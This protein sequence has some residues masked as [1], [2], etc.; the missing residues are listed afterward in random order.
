MSALEEALNA[1]ERVTGYRPVKSG[2]GYKARCPCHEDHNPSLSVKMNGR[3]L[4]HCFAGCSYDRIVAAL[5][6]APEP[7]SDAS[8]SPR[9]I[10]V[11]YRYRDESGAEVRQKVRYA[12]KDF[13][14]RHQDASG[15][16]VYK[17][18]PGPAVLYRL[19]ELQQ[20]IAQGA[21]VFVVEGEKDGD[22][23]AAGGLTATTN[24][25]GAAQP[26][27]KPKWR[28][29]YTAQLA[30]AARVVLLPDHDAPGQAHMQA[31]ARA[32]QGRVGD[33]RLLE[34]PGLPAKGDVSDW[35]NQGHT[36]TELLALAEEAAP[37][38]TA[39]TPH[40]TDHVAST[41]GDDKLLQE[42][43][44]YRNT[45][46][47]NAE[48]FINLYGKDVRYIP[49]WSKWLLWTGSHWQMDDTLHIGRLAASVSRA[50]YRTAGDTEDDAKR[51]KVATL[52]KALENG[53]RQAAMLT[54]VMPH[55]V[56]HHSE[57]DRS[58]FLL[59]VRNGTIDL[60]TG[61]LRPHDRHDLLT[62]NTAI[63]YHPDAIC[64]TWLWFLDGIFAADADLIRF[65]QRAIG[66]SLTGSTKEQVLFI[67]HGVG[68]NGK[69]K[70]MNL[71]RKLLE[72]LAAPAPSALLMTAKTE[73]HPTE[74]VILFRKRAVVAQETNEGQRFNESL[75]KQLTGEDAISARRMH[76]DFWEF[77]PTHKLWLATNHKP[78][79]KGTDH[80]IWRRIRLIPFTVTFHDPGEG[81]PVKDPDLE[82]KLTAE[83]PG[84]LA[85]AVKGC[86]DWQ[87][88]GLG[89]PQAVKNATAHYREEMDVLAAW[90]ADCCVVKKLTEAKAADLYVSYTGWCDAQ[91]ERP[92]SQRSFGLRL[93]E[94]G[95]EQKKRTGGNRYWLGIGLLATADSGASGASGVN[96]DIRD[97]HSGNGFNLIEISATCATCA[98]PPPP[99]PDALSSQHP[100]GAA[101]VDANKE[102]F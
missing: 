24:I 82:T 68:S 69:G 9:R 67:C 37:V 33:I 23:L 44:P 28:P 100:A 31:I 5:G 58:P 8:Q 81:E 93:T 63:P 99:P 64:P 85:W 11:T 50:L 54:A 76:E 19:P 71:L 34:L 57:L 92:E 16:W 65:V 79:I 74:L 59:N 97:I 18:G 21:T 46:L 4:L 47:A 96:S 70:L 1:L 27:Q 77:E 10:V 43:D 41:P 49:P 22:R 61:T 55:V 6:L 40:G 56:V 3:L 42:L 29:A 7:A 2:D 15:Q 52:A 72:S 78:N 39:T 91:G 20:A 95:F 73:R 36:V 89:M 32:L 75:V 80:A 86:L 14:I 45:D 83:L 30:G 87:R 84:I 90:I 35:L 88:H 51:R 98:T 26:G 13:R 17:A 25:E 60:T 48:L 66:Y 94:R 101:P 38:S 12:P 62:H 53:Q 102:R